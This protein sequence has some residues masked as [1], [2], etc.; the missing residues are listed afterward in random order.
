MSVTVWLR[1][2]NDRLERADRVVAMDLWGPPTEQ[3]HAATRPV[4][5][6]P[7]RIMAMIDG[8]EPRWHV[9]AR[10]ELAER[11]GELITGLIG[12]IA[13]AS[14]AADGPRYVYGLMRQ[15]SVYRWT[16]GLTIPLTDARVPPFHEAHDPVPGRWITTLAK[17]Q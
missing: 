10:C 17:P 16:H 5:G 8:E 4:A 11:G 7:A 15:G 13:A 1:L 12:A 3:D 6:H 9:V 2:A 14:R